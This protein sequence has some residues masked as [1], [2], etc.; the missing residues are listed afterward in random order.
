MRYRIRDNLRRT[1]SSDRLCEGIHGVGSNTGGRI[2]R[3]AYTGRPE[4]GSRVFP[5]WRVAVRGHRTKEL[6]FV[7]SVYIAEAFWRRSESRG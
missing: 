4:G 1:A 3:G 5:S 7:V 2:A 6:V